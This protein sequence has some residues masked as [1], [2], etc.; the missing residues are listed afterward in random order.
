MFIKTKHNITVSDADT[1]KNK[2]V[3]NC[4]VVISNNILNTCEIRSGSV[5]LWQVEIT[6]HFLLDYL[7]LCGYTLSNV[8]L[9]CVCC[10]YI[11]Y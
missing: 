5:S 2:T 8:V 9:T 11:I 10:C 1:G 7:A 6:F 4:V 3:I